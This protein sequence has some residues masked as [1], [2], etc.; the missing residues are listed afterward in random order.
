MMVLREESYA[1]GHPQNWE[2]C[3]VKAMEWEPQFGLNHRVVFGGEWI[4]YFCMVWEEEV[5]MLSWWIR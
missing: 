3:R 4:C 5:D 1:L 2:E